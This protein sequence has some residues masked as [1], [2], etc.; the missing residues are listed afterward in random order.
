M[1]RIR[2]DH[3]IQSLFMVTLLG[4]F[5]LCSIGVIAMGAHVYQKTTA[6]SSTDYQLRTSLTYISEKSR[7]CDQ[8]GGVYLGSLDDKTPALIF[9]SV[10]SETA[11]IT[12]IYSWNGTLRELFVKDGAPT[13]PD[14]GTEIMKL[15]DLTLEA[16]DQ[17]MIRITV[18]DQNQHRAFVLLQSNSHK[19][20][21]A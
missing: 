15:N 5:F 12:C 10:Y 3:M 8:D 7:Q 16:L 18:T 1:R 21:G 14:S 11:Y 17:G 4:L 2:S 13:L 20:A 6:E 9:P 19:E